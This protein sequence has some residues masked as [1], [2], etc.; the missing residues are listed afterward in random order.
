MYDSIRAWTVKL[1]KI[2]K[3]YAFT[4]Q[5]QRPEKDLNGW[6]I[7]NARREWK[8]LGISEKGT[9][10]GWRISRLNVDYSVCSRSYWDVLG[11]LIGLLVFAHVSSFA[12]YPF[13]DI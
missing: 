11:V 10:N 6:E 2:E 1:G 7:Y 8:R 5:P 3:L 13:I 12:P 4:Y 9:D